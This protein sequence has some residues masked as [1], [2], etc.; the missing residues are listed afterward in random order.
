M[1]IHVFLVRVDGLTRRFAPRS[2]GG[3]A[4]G[5]SE[6]V[7]GERSEAIHVVGGSPTSIATLL[8]NSKN[9]NRKFAVNLQG[10][11]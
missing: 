1:A 11:C 3:M 7:H 10:L 8:V 4:L 6:A 2:D 5:V 9:A